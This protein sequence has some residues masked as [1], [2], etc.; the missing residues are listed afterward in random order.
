MWMIDGWLRTIALALALTGLTPH[1]GRASDQQKIVTVLGPDAFYYMLHYVAEGAGLFKE[2]GLAVDLVTVNSGSRQVATVMGGSA[3][4]AEVNLSVVIQGQLQGGDMVNIG[5]VYDIFPHVLFLSTAAMKRTGITPALSLEDKVNRLHGLKIGITSPGSGTD[6]LMRILFI[7][8]G[9]DP[10][11]EV[12][13]LP[14]GG[15][16]PMMAA[17]KQQ[18]IDGFVFTAPLPQAA[19]AEG[20]GQVVVSP[21]IGEVP[22]LRSVPYMALVTSRDALAN[23]KPL[24]RSLVR[25]LTKARKYVQEKPVEARKATRKYF[26]DMAEDVFDASFDEHVKGLPATLEISPAQLDKT[27]AFMN[28]LDKKTVTASYADVVYPDLAHEAAAEI[29]GR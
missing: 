8:R 23:K 29:L 5:S 13:L 9:K 19:T 12:V 14:L 20:L 10:D 21:F 16:P 22:E 2:E 4:V 24:L 18:A 7:G 17:L 15:G 27:L 3:E 25:A 6:Q 1:P 28:A 11:Q 26:P